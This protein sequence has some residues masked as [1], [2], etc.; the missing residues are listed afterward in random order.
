MMTPVPRSIPSTPSIPLPEPPLADGI[1]RLRPWG[2]ADVRRDAAALAAAWHDPDVQRWSAVPPPQLR[3]IEH[4]EGWITRE[5]E[6]RRAGLAIDLVIAP[7]EPEEDAVLGEVGL[8]PIDWGTMEAG[9][10]WWVAPASRGR[11]IATR[12]VT[13]LAWWARTELALAPVAVVDPANRA[14]VRVAERAGVDLR[15]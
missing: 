15:P 11:G 14:S 13:L 3:T 2:A 1:V 8:A 12:A 10:G 6:R 9:V 7:A 4:A 5:A